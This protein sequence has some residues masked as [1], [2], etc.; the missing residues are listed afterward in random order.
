MNARLR[1]VKLEVSADS[2]KTWKA[3]TRNVN[4][5]FE[6]TG[7]TGTDTAWVRA[8][9]EKGDTVVVQNVAMTSGKT[10]KGSTNYKA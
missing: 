8:T 6:I 9:S 1:T 3:T 10:T 4:N 7:G 2:G 5:Y